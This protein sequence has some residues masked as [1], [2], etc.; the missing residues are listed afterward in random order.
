MSSTRNRVPAHSPADANER[1]QA[2]IS[3]SVRYFGEHKDQIP[4]RL[5]ELDQEWDI[6][7]AIE[8]NA[9]ALTLTGVM[10]AAGH[11]RR[12]LIL[13]GLVSAFLLQHAIQGWCPP[14]P[15]LRKLGFRTSYEIE[16]ER[17]ALKALKGD[18]EQATDNPERALSGAAA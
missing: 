7:R 5:Q 16:E 6:E 12:W 1:I 17:R 2:G 8:A 11:D 13:P 9:S 14:V 10:L 18:F 15:V 4:K 3:A